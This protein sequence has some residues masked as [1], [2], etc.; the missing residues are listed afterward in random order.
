[1]NLLNENNFAE[2]KNGHINES[3]QAR[4]FTLLIQK[5]IGVSEEDL[6]ANR[7]GEFPSAQRLKILQKNWLWVLVF[8]VIIAYFLWQVFSMWLPPTFID[9]AVIFTII[10]LGLMFFILGVLYFTTF[11]TRGVF[12]ALLGQKVEQVEGVAHISSRTSGVGKSR[13]TQYFL[14]IYQAVSLEIPEQVYNVLVDGLYYRI[15]YVPRT[16]YLVSA[17][18]LK[19]EGKNEQ[20]FGNVPYKPSAKNR[21]ENDMATDKANSALDQKIDREFP[22]ETRE[23]ARSSLNRLML[24]NKD[25]VQ[26]RILE[27][28]KGDAAMVE[29]LVKK[30]EKEDDYREALM[31]LQ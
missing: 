8:V 11:G 28:A 26:K 19:L 31:F 16:K 14:E 2:N 6:A 18:V 22:P 23:K 1:M 13:R 29:S 25:I 20:L 24:I 15:F 7:N 27:L 17:E 5:V 10:N 12:T 9:D 21:G 30:V 4:E 3:Q